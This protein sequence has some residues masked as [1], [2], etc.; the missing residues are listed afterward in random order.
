MGCWGEGEEARHKVYL[1][2]AVNS[3]SLGSQSLVCQFVLQRRG[4]GSHIAMLVTMVTIL[5]ITPNL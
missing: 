1:H 4:S 5:S 3:S 2:I